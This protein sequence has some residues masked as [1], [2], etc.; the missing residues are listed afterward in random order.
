MYSNT[1][2]LCKYPVA[3]HTSIVNFNTDRKFS[4]STT[5]TLGTKTTFYFSFV[6]YIFNVHQLDCEAE[7]SKDFL[8]VCAMREAGQGTSLP[9]VLGG[10]SAGQLSCSWLFDPY[11][12]SCRGR[13]GGSNSFGS[14]L[15]SVS[16]PAVP[17]TRWPPPSPSDCSTSL[18]STKDIAGN[19]LILLPPHSQPFS[20][21]TLSRQR[22]GS[23]E[24]A[25]LWVKT[26]L[27][28]SRFLSYWAASDR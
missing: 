4:P 19:F 12:S 17:Y 10:L 5:I 7:F 28:L 20:G 21:L 11:N 1:L 23:P 27:F 15:P 8:N 25:T 22:I 14:L 6:L 2:R 24:T 3:S 16:A 13:R 9:S 18:S 26:P